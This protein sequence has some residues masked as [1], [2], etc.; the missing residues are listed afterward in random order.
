MTR[1][2]THSLGV[3]LNHPEHK[4]FGDPLAAVTVACTGTL[5][6]LVLRDQCLYSPV[7][8][9][10][11]PEMTRNKRARIH[12]RASSRH[13]SFRRQELKKGVRL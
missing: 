9:I 1:E 4:T 2:E 5:D 10:G 6:G 3:R 13:R 8:G 11:G 7:C 12:F